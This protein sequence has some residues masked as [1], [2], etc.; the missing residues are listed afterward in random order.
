MSAPDFAALLHD[1]MGLDVSSIGATAVERAVTER[2]AA[3]KLADAAAYWQRLQSSEAERQELV[4]AVVVPETWFFRDREAYAA[5]A[6]LAQDAALR[7]AAALRLLSLPCATGEEPY[8]MAMALLDAGLGAAQFRIDAVDI[9]ERAL[10]RA[11]LGE[12]GRNSFRGGELGF[13]ERHFEAGAH[14]F[15]L[16]DRVRSAVQFRQANLLAPD[17]N[18]G[19]SAYDVIFCRNLLIYFD[20]PTQDRALAV[21]QRRLLDSGTLF[22][23]PAE[24]SLLLRH[25]FVSARLPMAF[26]FRKA[27]AEPAAPPAPAARK[28]VPTPVS[29]PCAPARR[30][31]PPKRTRPA[32]EPAPQALR[33]TSLE[34]AAR[35]AD[36]GQLAEAAHTCEALLREQGPSAAVFQL[37]GVVRGAAGQLAEAAQFFRK[38]LYLQPDHAEALAHLAYTLEQQGDRG[39]AQ[40]LRARLR[41]LQP[42]ADGARPRP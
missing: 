24:T 15:R 23:G 21:L 30:T 28:A 27:V 35:L 14:G 18:P 40:V 1:I 26:A 4:E 13:R 42:R 39:G 20:V 7:H 2:V 8:S 5:L 32:P 6:Q 10:A 41:R 25:D 22:V 11:R 33:G 37:L 16:R 36:Q 9:S 12:Y 31:P 3:C 34:R 38:A 19:A 17:F 29:V